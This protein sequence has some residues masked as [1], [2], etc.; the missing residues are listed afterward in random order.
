MANG[1]EQLSAFA[2]PICNACQSSYTPGLVSCPTCFAPANS[3][4]TEAETQQAVQRNVR[5][6][7]ASTGLVWKKTAPRGG[8]KIGSDSYLRKWG[9]DALKPRQAS[10]F[11][12][13]SPN[14]GQDRWPT[15]LARYEA[16]ANYRA[17]L[18][19]AHGDE[20]HAFMEKLEDLMA[21]GPQDQ[22]AY[23]LSIGRRV[24]RY[25]SQP[26]RLTQV[27]TKDGKALG[28][29]SHATPNKSHPDYGVRQ[30]EKARAPRS[31]GDTFEGH[32]WWQAKGSTPINPNAG[33]SSSSASGNQ[34]PPQPKQSASSAGSY[35][36]KREWSGTSGAAVP[37]M[38]SP[39]TGPPPKANAGGN[40][41]Q[42]P[43][44]PAEPIFQ[45]AAASSSNAGGNTS[46]LENSRD[47]RRLPM[48]SWGRQPNGPAG[49]QQDYLYPPPKAGP[50]QAYSGYSPYAY[51]KS[52]WRE[53]DYS[54]APPPGNWSPTPK[55]KSW[56]QEE[57]WDSWES[58]ARG[59][60]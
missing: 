14:N 19:E 5:S 58:Q 12:I 55:A 60:Q 42:R 3:T 7:R 46:Q 41:S 50:A 36:F 25:G 21:A 11:S 54:Y 29:G 17:R 32:N 37:P 51:P 43:K 40:T 6:A 23:S 47:V 15:I 26:D 31:K 16:C 35:N 18:N 57:W 33:T 49:S 8:R 52:T 48:T 10:E 13:C 56:P 34:P 39:P 45:G 59:Y 30:K 44:S 20:V 4:L 53:Y 1:A 24:D 2:N 27:T 38:M 28:G 9:L 22:V